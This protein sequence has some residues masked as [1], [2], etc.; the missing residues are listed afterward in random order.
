MNNTVVEQNTTT[1]FAND[2]GGRSSRKQQ[3]ERAWPALAENLLVLDA[4]LQFVRARKEF[5]G[6][7]LFGDVYEGNKDGDAVWWEVHT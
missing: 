2:P 4:R 7:N 1:S 6:P 3:R 5:C